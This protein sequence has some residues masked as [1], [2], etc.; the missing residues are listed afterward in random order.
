MEFKESMS[1]PE[2]SRAKMPVRQ[3]VCGSPQKEPTPP[4]Q[5]LA[6]LF[7]LLAKLDPDTQSWKKISLLEMAEDGWANTQ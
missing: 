6:E 1:S 2:A 5:D 7:V 3:G 4:D